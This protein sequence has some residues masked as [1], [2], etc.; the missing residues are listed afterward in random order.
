MKVH[1]TVTC[2]ACNPPQEFYNHGALIT[3]VIW[4]HAARQRYHNFIVLL[5]ALCLFASQVTL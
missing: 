1:C 2:Y 3:H 4:V 5:V